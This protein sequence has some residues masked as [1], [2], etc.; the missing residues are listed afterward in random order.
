[1]IA[2]IVITLGAFLWLRSQWSIGDEARMKAMIPHHSSAIL[3]SSNADLQNPAVKE[4]AEQ[5][6]ITQEEEIALMKKL[7]EEF[8]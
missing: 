3:T 2:G 1:M 6:I 8:E 4:L 5:I 7:L